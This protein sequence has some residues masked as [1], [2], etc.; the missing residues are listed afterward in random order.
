MEKA[1]PLEEFDYDSLPDHTRQKRLA[2]ILLTVVA[3][4]S[5]FLSI[6][7]P[8]PLDGIVAGIPI[9]ALAMTWVYFDSL[10]L[11][12]PIDGGMR[13]GVMFL[14]M[15]MVPIYF[16]R[17]RGKKYGTIAL[18]RMIGLVILLFLLKAAVTLTLYY[19]HI[20]EIR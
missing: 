18:M 12:D 3:A 4:L 20:L 14:G 11:G 2:V 13:I 15:L 5:P 7:L 17:S 8:M 9:N 19:F 6:S 16:Y 1:L 10:E